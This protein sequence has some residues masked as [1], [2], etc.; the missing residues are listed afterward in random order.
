MNDGGKSDDE[1]KDEA[2]GM[3]ASG[4]NGRKRR[5]K[6]REKGSSAL[7]DPSGELQSRQRAIGLELRRMF[8]EIVEEPIPPDFLNLLDEIDRKRDQ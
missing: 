3:D 5:R 1:P 2:E 6:P 4:E 7:R 8:D